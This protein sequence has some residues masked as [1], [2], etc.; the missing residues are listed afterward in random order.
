MIY[1]DAVNMFKKSDVMIAADKERKLYVRLLREK[2][3]ICGEDV[4]PCTYM[5][6]KDRLERCFR[7]EL[8]S[9]S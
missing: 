5:S 2:C 7:E 1:Y 9:G 6:I 8:P 4:C 3:S